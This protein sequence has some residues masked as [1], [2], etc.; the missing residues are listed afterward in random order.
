VG[1]HAVDTSEADR[2][3]TAVR[4]PDGRIRLFTMRTSLA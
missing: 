1:E 4:K 3:H 2:R